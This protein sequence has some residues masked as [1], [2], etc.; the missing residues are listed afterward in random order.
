MKKAEVGSKPPNPSIAHMREGAVD[1]EHISKYTQTHLLFLLDSVESLV[2][3]T[4]L[5][6]V[7]HYC[8]DNSQSS[9]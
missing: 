7:D 1:F 6:T 5:A 9:H 8:G 2:Y 3:V 4:S